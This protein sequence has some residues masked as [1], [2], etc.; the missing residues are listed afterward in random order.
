MG[1][2]HTVLQ[3]EPHYFEGAAIEIRPEHWEAA[4]RTFAAEPPREVNVLVKE[5]VYDVPVFCDASFQERRR[6]VVVQSGGKRG[7]ETELEALLRR[8]APYLVDAEFY[9]DDEW[10]GYVD[11]YRVAEGELFVDRVVEADG[12]VF[13]YLDA[14]LAVERPRVHARLLVGRAGALMRLAASWERHEAH[15]AAMRDRRAALT[16][17]GRAAE[18]DADWRIRH[19]QAVLLGMLDRREEARA[20]LEVT[21]ASL[22]GDATVDLRAARR[23]LRSALQACIAA[24]EAQGAGPDSE[25]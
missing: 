8:L 22:E 11:R 9:V 5:F 10:H 14:T 6:F 4:G 13:A 16:L 20:L 25:A 7:Y 18:R 2:T 15:E 3:V 23:D 12:E 19:A 24:L 21:L 17:L 1:N